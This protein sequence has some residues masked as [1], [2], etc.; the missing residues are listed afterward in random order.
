MKRCHVCG[1]PCSEQDSSD[2]VVLCGKDKGRE[3]TLCCGCAAEE[4]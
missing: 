3:I 1:R 2:I 4:E